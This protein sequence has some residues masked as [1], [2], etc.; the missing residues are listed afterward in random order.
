MRPLLLKLHRWAGLAAGAFVLILAATGALLA[1]DGDI[2]RLLNPRLLTVAPGPSRASL[3]RVVESV[4]AAYP[5]EVITRLALPQRPDDAIQVLLQSGLTAGVDPHSGAVLGIRDP[6][7]SLVHFI[8][9]LHTTLLFGRAGRWIVGSL[10]ALTLAM[11]VSG[12]ILWWPRRI[13]RL[14]AGRSW[15]RVNFDLHNLL[16]FY[17]AFFLVLVT[18]SGLII[19]FQEI[20]YPLIL[21]LDSPAQP[22]AL[23]PTAGPN[24][25]HVTLDEAV[26]IADAALPGAK[27]TAVYPPLK[28]SVGIRVTRK[29]PEDRRPMGRSSVAI[30]PSTGQV[31]Q[32][33]SGREAELGSRIVVMNRVLHVGELFGR[34]TRAVALLVCLML[35]GQIF[36][37]VLIWWRPGRLAVRRVERREIEVAR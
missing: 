14:G 37:G 26:R 21:K 15:R 32:V 23:E 9:A 18:V 34:P 36:T 35:A 6:D 30:D 29:F 20:T 22:P 17:S 33:V 1:F 27:T 13:W 24:G 11:A 4:R 10:T 19:S 7:K 3:D 28:R 12:L 16:G 25:N 2:D 31:R 5:R 8:L